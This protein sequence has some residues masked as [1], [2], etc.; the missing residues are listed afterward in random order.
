MDA[1]IIEDVLLVLKEPARIANAGATVYAVLGICAGMILFG[2][3]TYILFSCGL[4]K[5]SNLRRLRKGWLAWLPFGRLW[6]LGNLSDDYRFAAT[7]GVFTRRRLLPALA[8]MQM[9]L[10]G[11]FVFCSAFTFAY[12]Y[13]WFAV[14][15]QFA[16]QMTACAKVAIAA[17][18]V[19]GLM[20]L[21]HKCIAL[22][23]IYISCEPDRVAAYLVVSMLLPFT[24]PFLVF[25]CRKKEYGMPTKKPVL[26]LPVSWQP[27]QPE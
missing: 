20:L 19:F 8:L 3:I 5:L 4:H 18:A 21:I 6:V 23:D 12:F 1:K 2:L 13:K 15:Y 17:F 16:M 27:T 26:E 24:M 11:A 25:S 10:L 14:D 7:R 9:L 22:H